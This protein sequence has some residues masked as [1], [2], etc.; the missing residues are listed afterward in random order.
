L[1]NN[2]GVPEYSGT[3]FGYKNYAKQKNTMNKVTDKKSFN[4]KV[5]SG[6]GLQIVKF[7]AEWSGPCQMMVPIY[8]ELDSMYNSVASFYRIDVEEAPLLKKELGVI[9]MPTILFYR[10]GVV[11]D[12]VSGLISKNSLITKLENVLNN[13]K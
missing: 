8:N 3:P 4:E 7:Y 9:E 1:H 13:K 6:S 2:N 12:F 11:I 5:L 10:N